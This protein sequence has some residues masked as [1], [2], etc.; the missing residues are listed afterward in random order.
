MRTWVVGACLALMLGLPAASQAQGQGRR[1]NPIIRPQGHAGE[2]LRKYKD[3][4]P[5]QQQKALE[6][7]PDFQRLPPFRQ[8]MLRQRL[9]H[10][11]SLPPEQQQRILNRMETWEHLTPEQREQTR[12][13][14]RQFNALPPG[15]KFMV[16]RAVQRLRQMPPEQRQ[17]LIDSDRFRNRFTPQERELLRGVSQLP[18]A[19]A[20]ENQNESGQ[21][22]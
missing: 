6:N 18:L 12:Q 14:F 9:Q 15:R 17:Q 3:L 19:P 8:Q 13:L 22:E 16:R 2:W 5:A 4:P 21:E 1:Q 20:E 7:D 11:S 10:F